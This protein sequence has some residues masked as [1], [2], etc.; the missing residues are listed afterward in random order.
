MRE[1]EER[2][3]EFLAI[4]R[5]VPDPRVERTRVHP[6]INILTIA[7]LSVICVGDGWEDME[8]FGQVK[9]DWLATFLDLSN[10]VPSADTFRRVI[11]ALEPGA[12][13][14]CFM[15]WAQALCEGTAGKL[16]ALDGKTVRH[17]FDGATGKKALHLVNA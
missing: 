10:G 5:E 8:E 6:L 16:V 11:S 9:A 17:S 13:N 7:L 1:K 15:A 2:V 14:A 4:F 3:V 12:F